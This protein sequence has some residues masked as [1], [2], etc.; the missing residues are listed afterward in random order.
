[1]LVLTSVHLEQAQKE[2][3]AQL[4]KQRSQATG[5]RVTSAQLLRQAV[6]IFLTFELSQ[7][8]QSAVDYRA[9]A[10]NKTTAPALER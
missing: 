10:T 7:I 5:R 2:R 3:L 1:M 4:A 8:E 6:D 9:S